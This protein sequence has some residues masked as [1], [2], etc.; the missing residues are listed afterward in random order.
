MTTILQWLW[1]G[2]AIALAVWAVLRLAPRINAATRYAIWVVTLVTVLVLPIV[3]SLTPIL[4]SVT[5]VRNGTET[6]G[7]ESLPVVEPLFALPTL[8]DWL[9][10]SAI[11][12]WLGSVL[13]GFGRL[14]RGVVTVHQL[15]QCSRPLTP[16]VE[17]SLTLRREWSRSGR[18]RAE[19]R[20][21]SS[22]SG[23]CALGL[24]GPPVIVLSDRLI[25]T[26]APDD[27]DLIVLHEQVH[28]ARYDDWATLLQSGIHVVMGWHPG[29]R[30]IVAGLDAEREAACDE[31]VATRIGNAARYATCLADAADVIAARRLPA[32]PAVAPHAGGTGL[33]L[34]RVQRLLDS[35]VGRRAALQ[36][37]TL[38]SGVIALAT[39]SVVSVA[40]GPIVGAN[41]PGGLVT[42][43][44][45]PHP[46]AL[47]MDVSAFGRPPAEHITP[48]ERLPIVDS[49]PPMRE[50]VAGARRTSR[51]ISFEK[52][53][54]APT[55]T[56]SAQTDRAAETPQVTRS[57]AT[58]AIDAAADAGAVEAA[59]LP[60]SARTLTGASVG[61]F[62]SGIGE[63]A[64]AAMS[65]APDSGPTGWN[66]VSRQVAR[67]SAAIGQR[68]ARRTSALGSLV[69]RAG[70]AV[71]EQF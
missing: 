51:A 5:S 3:A 71:A 23:A 13:I 34:A 24:L 6:R 52:P 67:Q 10:A 68:V 21:S 9:I 29:I 12:A 20:A 37:L 54:P 26:L 69:G 14:A 30:V 39:A 36:R 25:A 59:A 11:G 44:S 66:T 28:L 32:V 55:A 19:L 18:R 63:R 41:A 64:G 70:K 50:S 43:H 33:L 35:R 16:A 61:L 40:I 58:P 42:R 31:T 47:P 49:V 38:C 60:L 4:T 57:S 46:M 15:K 62:A 65:V 17:R 8:P 56:P 1:Q 53:L 27:L 2:S 7:A 45:T 48:L 22:V